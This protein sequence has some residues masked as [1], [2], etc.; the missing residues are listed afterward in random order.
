MKENDYGEPCTCAV[1][2][3]EPHPCP[4]NQDV[5]DDSDSL[6]TCCTS[7]EAQCVMEI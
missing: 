1:E 4:F 5:N 2:V 7:C 6:C 3:I